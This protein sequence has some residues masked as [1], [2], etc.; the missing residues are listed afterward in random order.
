MKRISLDEYR[1]DRVLDLMSEFFVQE[2]KAKKMAGNGD[3]FLDC[4]DQ[5]MRA[6]HIAFEIEDEGLMGLAKEVY[7]WQKDLL[8]EYLQIYREFQRGDKI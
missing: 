7:P 8:N 6:A 4:H 5:Q 2:T 3:N 1:N